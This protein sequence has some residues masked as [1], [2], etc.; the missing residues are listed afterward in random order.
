MNVRFVG[1]NKPVTML[2]AAAQQMGITKENL[3]EAPPEVQQQLQM[4]AMNPQAQ[5]VVGFEN[6]V[7]ELDVDIVIDEGIDTPTV[8]AEQFEQMV[9]MA[10]SGVPI[11]PDVLIEASSL[12]NKDK[13]LE[14]LRAPNPMQ[15]MQGQVAMAGAQAKIEETQSKTAK[16]MADAEATQANTA[17][18]A[19]QAGMQVGAM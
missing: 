18:S 6:N 17:L 10:G 13:L 7:T 15:E 1:L 11:P 2:Q 12:R 9:K 8:A 16:N 5:A 4:M 3:A 14:M 19:M